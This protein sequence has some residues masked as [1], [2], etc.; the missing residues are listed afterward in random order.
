MIEELGCPEERIW[1]KG[2]GRLRCS[3]LCNAR[4]KCTTCIFLKRICR[5]CGWESQQLKG[6]EICEKCGS[7]L[8]LNYETVY[9]VSEFYEKW[10]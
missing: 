7:K 8:E 2:E 6:I 1:F 10:E 3:K 5:N 9:P 4:K